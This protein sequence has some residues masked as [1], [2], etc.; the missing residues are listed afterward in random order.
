[1]AGLNLN[2]FSGSRFQHV[3]LHG[4]ARIADFSG[5]AGWR[6]FV[7]NAFDKALRCAIESSIAQA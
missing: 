1:M 7:A 3:S 6:Y 4:A 5:R 2:P